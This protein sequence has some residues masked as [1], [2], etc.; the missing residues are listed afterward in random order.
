MARLCAKRDSPPPRHA[1]GAGRDSPGLPRGVRGTRAAEAA[2]GA[3]LGSPPPIGFLASPRQGQP[4]R[5][6]QTESESDP[7]G[8]EPP[9]EP[10][11][12]AGAPSSSSAALC[13]WLPTCPEPLPPP[14]ACVPFGPV[15]RSASATP[16]SGLRLQPARKRALRAATPAPG[17][18]L[19]GS[20]S[21]WLRA[22]PLAPRDLAVPQLSDAAEQLRR[23]IPETFANS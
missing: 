23:K 18:R 22:R 3:Q 5:A 10:P 15:L 19:P 17:P 13:A 8:C 21:R 2:A 6:E 11:A 12:P 4:G 9:G 7:V 14:P 20:P 16:L 1:Q